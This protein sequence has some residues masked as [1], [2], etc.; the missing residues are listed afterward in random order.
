M[1][2]SPTSQ[3]PSPAVVAAYQ[4]CEAVAGQHARNFKYGARLVPAAKRQA[5]CAIYAFA[6]RV[7]DIGDGGLAP[8]VK[9][10][11]LAEAR[12]LLDRVRSG[13]V[14]EDDVDPV[15]VA[16]A[17]ASGAYPIPLGGLDELIDGVLMDV[18]GRQYGTWDELRSYCRCV[19]GAIGRL[20]LGVFG[21]V[22]GARHAERADEYADTLGL[23]LQLTN[24]L[25]D[26]REDAE[27]G[28]TYL[29]AEDLKKF[30]FADHER[31]GFADQGP[32]GL[33][34]NDEGAAKLVP[35]AAGGD[36]VGLVRFE[37]A[38]AR[39]LF[40]EGFRLLPMLDRRSGACV[41]A[42]A[43]TYHRLLHRIDE[44]PCAVLRGRVG[45]PAA[46]KVLVAVRG[47]SGL[48]ARRAAGRAH[49]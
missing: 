31:F 32:F 12:A 25:R 9:E 17:H 22:P 34:D 18:R 27:N 14:P 48:E 2:N 45:L 13:G 36:F 39:E 16:L 46:Q 40:A 47:L 15:A 20:T 41:A 5:L 33:V 28:R 29:P 38:R 26:I 1:T 19:A 35:P 11:R 43:G 44:D 30:G 37:V 7:D 6:R 10:I 49:P 24:I 42:M 23:A 8:D 21:T 3:N 4:Y